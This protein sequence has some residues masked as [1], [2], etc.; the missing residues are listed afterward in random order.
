MLLHQAN[1][2]ELELFADEDRQHMELL[3]LG[4][5]VQCGVKQLIVVWRCVIGLDCKSSLT[6]FN[7]TARRI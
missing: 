2:V 1:Y 4:V 7:R 5:E 6:M 3:A